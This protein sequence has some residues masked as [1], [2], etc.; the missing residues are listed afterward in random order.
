MYNSNSATVSKNLFVV[1]CSLAVIFLLALVWCLV[2]L[3]ERPA[4]SV[5]DKVAADPE[6]RFI[7]VIKEDATVK[8]YGPDGSEAEKCG[9]VNGT[10]VEGNCNIRGKLVNINTLTIFTTESSPTCTGMFISAGYWL[11]NICS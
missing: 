3:N 6:T 9:N 7:T 4:E 2:N 10:K 1:S 8:V 11:D 5:L